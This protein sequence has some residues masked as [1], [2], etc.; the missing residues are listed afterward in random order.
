MLKYVNINI[1]HYKT[2]HYTCKESCVFNSGNHWGKK[3]SRESFD[4]T[5][6]SYDGA[7]S[8]ELVGSLLLH[9]ISKKTWQ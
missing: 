3:S 1:N 7:E 9:L 2:N 8:C 6:G 5:M 4:I